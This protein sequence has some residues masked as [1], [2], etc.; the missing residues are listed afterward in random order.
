MLTNSG[1]R[2]RE[3]QLKHINLYNTL[4]EK[5]K[6]AKQMN[7]VLRLSDSFLLDF[8]LMKYLPVM[9]SLSASSSHRC[10]SAEGGV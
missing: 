2:I 1:N 7:G 10:T 4:L 8:H 9:K 3:G 5:F 6:E